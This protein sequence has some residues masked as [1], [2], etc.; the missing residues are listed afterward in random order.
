[1]LIEEL[2]ELHEYYADLSERI[3]RQGKILSCLVS[4]NENGQLLKTIPGVGD[5]AAAQCLSE[6]ESGQHIKNGRNLAAW[7][8]LVPHQH[9]TGSK[10]K[11]LSI[12]KRGY[13]LLR[14]LFIHGTRAILARSEKTGLV[15]GEWL[16]GLRQTKPVKVVC[17]AL[18]N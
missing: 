9:S 5:L 1:M 6:F 14:T 2:V 13:K 11:C 17:V 4:E 7:L 15:F 12:G 16:I 8:G 3:P 18:A 10:T